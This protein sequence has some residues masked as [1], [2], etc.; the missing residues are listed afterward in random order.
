MHHPC[1]ARQIVCRTLF[2]VACHNDHPCGAGDPTLV[3]RYARR[4]Q[5]FAVLA[6]CKHGDA[7]G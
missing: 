4:L 6:D 3:L 5:T 7:G 1:I 2:V